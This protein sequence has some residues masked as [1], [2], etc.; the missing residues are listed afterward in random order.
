[1]NTTTPNPTPIFT[2]ASYRE[3]AKATVL[4]NEEGVRDPNVMQVLS[5]LST[6]RDSI[7]LGLTDLTPYPVTFLTHAGHSLIPARTEDE[8]QALIRQYG[9][10]LLGYAIVKVEQADTGASF[11]HVPER[12]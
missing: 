10:S 8:A 11:T 9:D 1:M 2:N 6:V 3:A 5:I 4:F 7:E 12:A